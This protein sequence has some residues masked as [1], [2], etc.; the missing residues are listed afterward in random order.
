VPNYDTANEKRIRID[1]KS[2]N[3]RVESITS[4]NCRAKFFP[5]DNI[6]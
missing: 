3:K 4:V 5:E 1:K 6:L 2:K